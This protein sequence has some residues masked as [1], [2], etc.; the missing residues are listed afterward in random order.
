LFFRA[1][2]HGRIQL[3]LDPVVRDV[4]ARV[5]AELRESL[6]EGSD[7]PSLR[8][9]F[10]TAYPDDPE[11]ERAYEQLVRDELVDSRLAALETVRDTVDADEITREQAEQ[12]MTALNSVRLTLGTQLDVSED[13]DPDDVDP[14]DP[15]FPQF[16]VYDLLSALLGSLIAVLSR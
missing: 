5:C 10:P 15:R 4:V 8:R 9:L 12:W 16:L 11:R 2:R 3:Q 14:D 13:R 1:R 7:D 6:S